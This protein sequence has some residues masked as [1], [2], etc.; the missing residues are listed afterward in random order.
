MK[1]L[2]ISRVAMAK[3][4]T[5]AETAALYIIIPPV[6]FSSPSAL[7]AVYGKPS[8]SD[9]FSVA[10]RPCQSDIEDAPQL[11]SDERAAGKN[12]TGIEI[13]EHGQLSKNALSVLKR[14]CTIAETW[15]NGIGVIMAA[16]DFIENGSVSL[17][18]FQWRFCEM[19]LYRKHL[20]LKIINWG[21]PL[22]LNVLKAEL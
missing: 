22:T 5:R 20:M 16:K 21:V 1:V 15:C 13:Q 11:L 14:F 6:S 10:V 9:P 17:N 4:T 19:D 2:L 12:P 7:K 8:N 18:N 3:V